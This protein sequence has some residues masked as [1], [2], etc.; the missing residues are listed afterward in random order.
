MLSFRSFLSRKRMH[1]NTPVDYFLLMCRE[2]FLPILFPRHC[3]LC[4]RILPFGKQICISC[5]LDLPWIDEPVCFHCGKPVPSP[6]QE[7]CYDCRSFSK[8]FH[9]G[10]ALFIYNEKTRPAMIQFK[11]HNRRVLSSF[12]IQAALSQHQNTLRSWGIQAI[13]PVP[14]HPHKQKERGYNQAGLLARDLALALHLPFYPNLLLR[15]MDTLPQKNFSP[16]A[17]LSN[18]QHA[19]V[20]NP[21]FRQTA[22]LLHTVLLIDDIYTTGATMEAC[23]RVLLQSG[24]QE[25]CIYS[26]CIGI[27]RD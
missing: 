15:Q 16:Q 14:I 25:V 22:R 4:G 11:Y 2:Q 21:R 17:R 12:F 19:F 1:R 20:L 13:V 7:L 24:V 9:H 3:P 6:E 10:R 8:S 23:S 26:I 5:S 18:M 27:S